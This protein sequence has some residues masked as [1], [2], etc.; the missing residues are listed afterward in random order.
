MGPELLVR[1]SQ[2]GSWIVVMPA[3]EFACLP[4]EERRAYGVK[5]ANTSTALVAGEQGDRR[6]WVGALLLLWS[7]L[8][9]WGM[10]Y[11]IAR[12]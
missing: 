5:F 11:F 8:V 2:R 3:R 1:D 12:G 10:W 6:D 7:G 9:F 4:T